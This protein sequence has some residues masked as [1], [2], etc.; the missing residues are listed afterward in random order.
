MRSIRWLFGLGF[1]AL[2]SYAG[3]LHT[4]TTGL[5]KADIDHAI[6]PGLHP[7]AR[8]IRLVESE[9]A[10]WRRHVSTLLSQLRTTLPSSMRRPSSD[11]ALSATSSEREGSPQQPGG[12]PDAIFR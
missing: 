3:Y 12:P 2:M 8:E 5:H 1:V 11:S 6:S 10:T 7:T 9:E 4:E